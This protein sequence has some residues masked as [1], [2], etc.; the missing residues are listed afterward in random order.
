MSDPAMHGWRLSSAAALQR[1]EQQEHEP[2]HDNARYE[3]LGDVAH[4]L[5][6]QLNPAEH[7]SPPRTSF[8][9]RDQAWFRRRICVRSRSETHCRIWDTRHIPLALTDFAAMSFRDSHVLRTTMCQCVNPDRMPGASADFRRR[10]AG[11]YAGGLSACRCGAGSRGSAKRTEAL[12]LR[13]LHGTGPARRSD[14]S[15][16]GCRTMSWVVLA[17]SANL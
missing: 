14:D 15:K 16:C 13:W 6:I 9:I 11:T 10:E 4:L 5:T 8:P 3:N 1:Q 12:S 7:P 2:E 17:R